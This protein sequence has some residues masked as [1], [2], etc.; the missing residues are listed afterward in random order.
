MVFSVFINTFQ[1]AT[2]LLTVSF[3][4]SGTFP[5]RVPPTIEIKVKV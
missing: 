2:Y 1:A 3:T 4:V 5:I